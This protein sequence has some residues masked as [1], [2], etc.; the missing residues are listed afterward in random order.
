MKCFFFINFTGKSEQRT[1]TYHEDEYSFDMSPWESYIDFD[2]SINQL[3]LTVVDG[4]IIQLSGF[5]GLRKEMISD[6]L[7]PKSKKGELRILNTN[8]YMS[9][10]GSYSVNDKD[11]PVHINIVTG[12]VCIGFP[13]RKGSAVEFIDNCIAIISDKQ[14][15]VSLWLKPLKLPFLL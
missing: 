14:E 4:K 6:F 8:K 5:C 13:E 12:W 1:L 10:I 7:T 3:C 2:L 11:F 9:G 15:L